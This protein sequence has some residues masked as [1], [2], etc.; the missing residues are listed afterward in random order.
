MRAAVTIDTNA[1]VCKP[2]DEVAAH[3]R[4]KKSDSGSPRRTTVVV[5]QNIA[6]GIAVEAFLTNTVHATVKR[7]AR[8]RYI[9]ASELDQFDF[10]LITAERVCTSKQVP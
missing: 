9:N 8:H 7:L 5:L 4:A 10:I 3:V 2:G 1:T 6:E